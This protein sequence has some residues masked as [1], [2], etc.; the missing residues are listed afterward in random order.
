MSEQTPETTAPEAPEAEQEQT[1]EST[2]EQA[3]AAES[4]E[5]SEQEQAWDPERAREKIRRINSENRALRERAT[6][7]EKKAET[8]PEL[9]QQNTTL[10]S[11]NLRL[12]VG[13][14]LGL[15]Y[16]L[17][18]RLQGSTREEMVADAEALVA[19][20]APTAKPAPATGTPVAALK[21]GAT[22]EH[23]QSEDDVLYTNLFG[24]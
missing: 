24:G 18:L 8:V 3:T 4:Q 9:Q 2:Q 13:Y 7:A 22:P 10:G 6:E 11:E 15:P 17:A 1:Q 19:L 23:T 20:V 12:R 16:N 14:E 5:E 21:P